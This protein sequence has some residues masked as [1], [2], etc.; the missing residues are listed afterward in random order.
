MG[1]AIRA[2]GHVALSD[3]LEVRHLYQK[4][5]RRWTLVPDDGWGDEPPCTRIVAI[6]IREDLPNHPHAGQNLLR[7]SS[8]PFR[9]R[10]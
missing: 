2:K 1:L 4:V 9:I 7:V 6:R 3:A 10:R 8:A 5:G